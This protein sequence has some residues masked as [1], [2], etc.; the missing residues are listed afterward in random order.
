VAHRVGPE[1]IGIVDGVVAVGCR[2]PDKAVD[3]LELGE[4]GCMLVA[5]VVAQGYT[6]VAVVVG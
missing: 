5:G 2:A 3:K 6:N 4:W 1:S